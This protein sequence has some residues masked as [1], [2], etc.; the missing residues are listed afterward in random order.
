MKSYLESLKEKRLQ[1]KGQKFLTTGR[2][3][4]AYEI[5]QK[6][7]LINNSPSNI[8]NLALSL[9]ALTKYSE[10]EEY[11]KK[12]YQDYPGNELN[13]L[14]LAECMIMQ[15]N[16]N[17]AI[18][19]FEKVVNLNP[20]SNAY[21]KYLNIAKDIVAREK[22]VKSR[23]LFNAATIKLQQKNDEQALKI[24]L[25][26]E[27]FFPGNPN[28]LNNIGTI[29]LILKD[30]KKAYNYFIKAVSQDPTNQKFQKNL[31]IAKRKIK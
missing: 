27:E 2:I 18:E 11:L 23:E 31:L 17:E 4:K 12:I 16:W 5:F 24:L 6:I 22:Y 14:A 21:K 15:K 20:L 19:F 30:Y 29:Y 13:T 10:A 26:A 28:I 1:R 7:L 25:E 8:Y 3:E 9:M